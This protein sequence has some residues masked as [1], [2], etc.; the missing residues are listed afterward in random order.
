MRFCNYLFP[1]VIK[2]YNLV[3]QFVISKGVRYET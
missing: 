1:K 2:K 3:S